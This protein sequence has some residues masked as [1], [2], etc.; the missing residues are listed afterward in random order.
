MAGLNVVTYAAAKAYTDQT[1]VGGGALKGKNCTVDSITDITG[2]HRVTFKWTL[3]NGTVQT[4]TMDVM[5]GVDGQDGQDGAPGQDGQDGL[6]PVITVDEITGGHRIT[7]TVGTDVETVDVMDGAKGEDGDPGPAGPGVP[8]GGTQGQVLKK[9]SGDDYDTEWADEEGGTGHGIPS[10]GTQGQVL[11]KTSNDDYDA[12]WSDDEGGQIIQVETLP[13]ASSTE[14]GNIYQYIGA[15]GGGITNGYFY[16]CVF[17]DP[18]YIWQAK[19]VQ[20]PGQALNGIPAGGTANQILQKHSNTDYDAEWVDPASYSQQQSDWDQSDN[21]QVDFIKN[22]PQNLVQDADYNHTDNNY[23]DAEVSKLAAIEAGAQVNVKPDWDATAGADDE[24]LNKPTLGTAA[25]KN[26][27]ASGDAGITEVVMGNDSRLTDAR[28]AADV[29]SWAKAE[30]KPAYT[31]SEV[32]A[33]STNDVGSANG[34]AGLDSNGKVPAAQLPSYVDDIEEYASESAFPA[35]GTSGKIYVALDTNKL[36]RWGGSAYAEVSES[37]ALGETSS[38]AYAGNKGKANADAI[39]AIKDGTSIDSFGDVETAL[40]NKQDTISDLSDIR[41]GASAGATAYQ[42]PS[43][44]ITT[45][46]LASGVTTSLGKADTAYQLP[47]GGI[48]T[49]DLASGVTT[50]LGKADTAYQKPSGGIPKT[51]LA[52]A[53]QTS[54]EK[55]D[56]AGY[57]V[58]GQD[59]NITTSVTSVVFTVPD[60]GYAYDPYFESADGTPVYVEGELKSGTTLT[61]TIRALTSAQLPCK[62]KLLAIPVASA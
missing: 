14:E 49:S 19:P 30:N 51:D 57:W 52:S 38:T 48:T 43:G 46:D 45:S 25:A 6:T 40:G 4:G 26:V 2:G 21:T 17:D 1:V 18:D 28:N 29:Y 54:L 47:S 36:Y 34:V 13:T 53:V 41:S 20:D 8:Q 16:K 11:R 12:D 35:T 3:D 33:V 24:I 32:G 62:A 9:V 22:K 44:G 15:T 23:T 55:A 50:S 7:I 58:A 56:G 60:A 39:T 37:L 10:G 42:L 59:K 5:D 27:P 31:A 61:Y